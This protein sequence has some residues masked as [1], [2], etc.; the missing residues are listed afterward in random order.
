MANINHARSATVYTKMF[1]IENPYFIR[2][3]GLIYSSSA[4]NS[5]TSRVPTNT[6]MKMPLQ[7]ASVGSS[8]RKEKISNRL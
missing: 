2:I 5:P 6:C 8:R 3:I 4:F 1:R 7:R